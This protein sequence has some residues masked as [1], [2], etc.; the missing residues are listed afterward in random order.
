MGSRSDDPPPGRLESWKEVARYLCVSVRTAQRWERSEA[1]P[2]HRHMHAAL[3]SVYAFPEELDAWRAGRPDV[4][5]KAPCRPAGRRA[6]AVLPFA[7]LNQDLETEI[8]ADGLTEE[9][10]NTLTRVDGL[11]VVART[12]V[13][14]FKNKEADIREIGAALS[15]DVV[16][17]GSVRRADRRLR[18]IAQLVDV[19]TG[20]HV[21]SEAFE[22]RR[23]DVFTLQADIAHAVVGRLRADAGSWPKATSVAGVTARA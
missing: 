6:V 14:H 12:S 8:I 23:A 3:G 15:V 19:G 4:Q 18:V 1:L 2:A 17:E 13:F 9:I 5:G 10:I 21:W 7:N 20:Q 11:G 16:I 22:S